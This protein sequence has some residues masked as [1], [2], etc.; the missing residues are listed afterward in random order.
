MKKVTKLNKKRSGQAGTI[1]LEMIA[2]AVFILGAMM[3]IA[4]Y[5]PK[6][7][8][9]WGRFLF[10][11]QA[12]EIAQYAVEW[13]GQKPNFLGVTLEKICEQTSISKSICGA[14][15]DGKATNSFGGD[16]SVQ[17]NAVSAGFLDVTATVIDTTQIPVLAEKVAASTREQCLEAAGC[18][19][20]KTTGSSLT[21]TY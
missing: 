10:V 9:I 15:N 19:S 4:S 14:N 2:A 17:P 5:N 6:I 11:N 8:N 13:K 3:V 1:S 18:G 16:W 7:Q 20:V 12:S 21:M